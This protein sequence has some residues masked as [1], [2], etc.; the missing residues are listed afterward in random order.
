MQDKMA[1]LAVKASE[2][3]AAGSSYIR[4][5]REYSLLADARQQTNGRKLIPVPGKPPTPP[6]VER[7]A[8]VLRRGKP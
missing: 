5:V 3:R 6:L 8:R 2:T 1:G 7:L 4:T